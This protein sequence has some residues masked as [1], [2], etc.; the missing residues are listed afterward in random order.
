MK[1]KHTMAL[2]VLASAAVLTAM[3]ETAAAADSKITILYDAF[4]TDAHDLL[5]TV[6]P[7]GRTVDAGRWSAR[8]ALLW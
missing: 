7:T 3:T 8:L 6:S 2:A 5:P 1:T 4:G